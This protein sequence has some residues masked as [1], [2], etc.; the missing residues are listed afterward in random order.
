[1]PTVMERHEHPYTEMAQ[2]ASDRDSKKKTKNWAIK[3]MKEKKNGS[4][5]VRECCL[6]EQLDFW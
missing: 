6:S 3:G 1:M 4:L 2:E 5:M